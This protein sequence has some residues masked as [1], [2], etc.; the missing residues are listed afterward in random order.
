MK[1]TTSKKQI[2]MPSAGNKKAS[3]LNNSTDFAI[4][5]LQEANAILQKVGVPKAFSKDELS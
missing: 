3:K 4:Q 2:K 1:I 5:K